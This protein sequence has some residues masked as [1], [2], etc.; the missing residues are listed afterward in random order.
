[1]LFV[2]FNENLTKKASRYDLAKAAVNGSVRFSLFSKRK[3][4]FKG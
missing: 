3:Y 4:F 1:M 2:N